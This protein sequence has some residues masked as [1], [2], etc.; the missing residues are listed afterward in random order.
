MDQSLQIIHQALDAAMKSGVLGFD[1]SE[2]TIV[3][4]RK[5]QGE[6][7]R[8]SGAVENL[9]EEN[10]ALKQKLDKAERPE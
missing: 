1:N 8:L 6:L 10:E 5:V 4:Y 2:K 7:S 3:A 9:S